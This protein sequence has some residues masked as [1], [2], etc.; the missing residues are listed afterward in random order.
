MTELE[1]VI[2]KIVDRKDV[3]L[4]AAYD[5]LKQCS[6]SSTVLDVMSVTAYW[7]EAECDGYC[8]LDDIAVELGME[9]SDA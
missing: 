7:D 8:L 4:Q 2:P 5:I 6:D 9:E 1:S 3:L